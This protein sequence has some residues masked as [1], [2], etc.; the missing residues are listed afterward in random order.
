MRESTV[1]EISLLCKTS[2]LEIIE[3]TCDI[4]PTHFLT[5][6]LNKIPFFFFF[7]SKTEQVLRELQTLT[8]VLALWSKYPTNRN[9][10]CTSGT[11]SQSMIRPKIFF[12]IT[13][14]YFFFFFKKYFT[15]TLVKTP[16]LVHLFKEVENHKTCLKETKT[17]A[18]LKLILHL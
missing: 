1:P 10:F 11:F 18:Y 4:Q 9:L 15:G 17:P 2:F 3:A 14:D 7:S 13:Q 6:K 5:I 8:I 16:S 12:K